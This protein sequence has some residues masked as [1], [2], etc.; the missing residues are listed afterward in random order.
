[1][2]TEEQK[3]RANAIERHIFFAALGL[4]FVAFILQLITKDERLSARIFVTG[5]WLAFAVGNFTTFYTGRLR[6]KNG[7]TFTR[8]SS[9]ILFYG[10]ALSFCIGTM[11]IATFLL[12]TAYTSK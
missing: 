3:E 10:S 11:S 6:W 7:P 9:P 4:G 8:E 2:P 12:W 5:F 1:M